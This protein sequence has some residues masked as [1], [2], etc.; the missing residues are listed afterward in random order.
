[1][2]TLPYFPD[3]KSMTMLYSNEAWRRTLQN[4]YLQGGHLYFY[5]ELLVQML[6]L[7]SYYHCTEVKFCP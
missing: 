2:S 1:M 5:L 6:K 3:L 7:M 4:Q